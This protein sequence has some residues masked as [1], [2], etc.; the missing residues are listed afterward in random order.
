VND[1]LPL[2]LASGSVKLKPNIRRFTET[3]VEFEDGS[4]LDNV[5][6]VVLATGIV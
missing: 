3:G 2:R 4:C 1:D 5:D 6:V